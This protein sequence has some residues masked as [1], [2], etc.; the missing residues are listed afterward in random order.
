[1]LLN[2]RQSQ[3]YFYTSRLNKHR[4]D[5]LY[6]SRVIKSELS[7]ALQRK[8]FNSKSRK[9]ISLTKTLTNSSI[10]ISRTSLKYLKS[11]LD[12]KTYHNENLKN[13]RSKLILE[14]IKAKKGCAPSLQ[15]SDHEIFRIIY[16]ELMYTHFNL[17]SQDV[18]GYKKDL[19]KTTI[20]LISG[21]FNEIFSTP[22]FKRGADYLKENYQL[23]NISINVSGVKDSV[24]NAAIIKQEL[25]S[26][27]EK[28]P[29]Q[30]LWI[31]SFSKGGLDTLHFLKNSE[32][33]HDKIKG[34][35]FIACPIL[36][37]EHVNHK[38][39]KALNTTSLMVNKVAK[40]N[41]IIPMAIEM[42]KS[43]DAK[44]RTNWFRVN[45]KKL[46]SNAFYTALALESKWYQSHLWMMLTKAFFMS[47]K[48]NDGIVDT[49]RA[50]FPQYFKGLNLGVL[51]GHHLI[52]SRSSF[53]NQEALLE[54]HLL[55]L[56]YKKLI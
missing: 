10:W 21:V 17:N 31:V 47:G 39:V 5:F 36:G 35:S 24:S 45:H 32:Q 20:V 8:D 6:A 43:L 18:F 11:Y 3:F 23:N 37:S 33:L 44:F 50:Q 30:K 13:P 27:C 29:H 9:L 34:I 4:K 48:S 46:P 26:Y 7:E 22:A 55:Y 1:M 51:E 52:G 19:S 16:Q 53:Y 12:L 38:V 49:D 2:D 54:A 56:L 42:R 14:A 25:E 40:N 41:A 28:N 15:V